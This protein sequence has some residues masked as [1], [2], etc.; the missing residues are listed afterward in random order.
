MRTDLKVPGEAGLSSILNDRFG[1]EFTPADQLFLDAIREDAV[2]SQE[3]QQV[4]H[5]NTMENFGFVFKKQL[6]D[7]FI[8]RMDQ[9]ESI[10]AKYM[11][12]KDFQA[13]VGDYLLKQV[14]DQ[15]RSPQTSA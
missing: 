8:D 9:N 10:T 15:I 14:Y 3:L 13:A 12:E 2:A 4:A 11:N 6:E 5:A 1:T 7:L